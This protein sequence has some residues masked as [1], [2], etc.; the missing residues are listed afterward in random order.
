MG[1]DDASVPGS[2]AGPDSAMT[3]SDEALVPLLV[4]AR[5]VSAAQVDQAVERCRRRGGTL[6]ESIFGL[7]FLAPDDLVSFLVADPEASQISLAALRPRTEVLDSLSA[8]LAR[9]HRVVPMDRV[10]E[11]LLVGMAEPLEES[12]VRE[13]AEA[14]GCDVRTLLVGSE[15]VGS[16][17]A[18]YYGDGGPS[19]AAAVEASH[20]HGAFK[21]GH[22]AQLI[23]N[24]QSLPALPETVDRVHDAMANPHS[25]V[26]DV[27]EIITMD[28]P[29]AAKVLSVANS[30]AYG[31]PQDIR[32]LNLAVS[33]LGLRETYAIVLSA[34]V[35]DFLHKLKDFDY[36]VFW[37]E[38]MCCA[39]ASRIVAKAAGRRNLPGVFTAGLLHDLGRPVLW[40]A[41][42]DLCRQIGNDVLGDEL[43][44]AEERVIGVSHPEAGYELALHWNLPVEIAETIRCHHRPADASAAGE[45]VA[46]VALADRMVHAAGDSVEANR[47]VFDGLDSVFQALGLDIENAE[48]MLDEYLRLREA[49]LREAD[50]V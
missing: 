19:R 50:E 20:L 9:K 46:I 36:R 21:L 29:V 7:G 41:V 17:L 8:G 3:A 28:P 14:S 26:A 45:H 38:S 27:V 39:A 48:A 13:L 23:R 24:I 5:L 40:E 18:L 47:D 32:D 43:A 2:G 34:A 22:V 16:A 15:D 25:S 12:A 37:L 49:A 35:V 42:P 10:G 31:F 33:L 4:Q 30:A 44:R 11:T 1:R 6:L